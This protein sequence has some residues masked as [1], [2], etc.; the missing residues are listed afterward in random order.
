MHRTWEDHLNFEIEAGSEQTLSCVIKTTQI[1][2]DP[3][4]WVS[5]VFTFDCSTIHSSR[6]AS[7]G[8]IPTHL[9][10]AGCHPGGLQHVMFVLIATS[11]AATVWATAG[12][13]AEL[14]SLG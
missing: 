10:R 11:N 8:G 5:A 12:A 6:S 13:V 4:K 2:S 1:D 9:Q 7:L 14:H 3:P